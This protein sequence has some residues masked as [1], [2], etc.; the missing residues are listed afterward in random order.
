MKII[1]LTLL[2]ISML[3]CGEF[4]NYL[5][6]EKKAEV[7]IQ[8][9][10]DDEGDYKKAQKLGIEAL[11][12]F[13]NNSF[14][15]AYTGKAFY[16]EGDLESAKKYFMQAL[17]IDPTN[18]I[19][20]QFIQLIEKQSNA[21]ENK[22]V[23]SALTYLNDKG[24]DY[25]LIFLAFLGGETIARRYSNCQSRQNLESIKAFAWT[26]QNNPALIQ[27]FLYIIT[28]TIKNPFC[29]FLSLLIILTTTVAITIVAIWI[30]LSIYPFIIGEEQL[31]LI[32]IA[33][34][35]IYG[36]QLLLG[37]ILFFTI[38]NFIN[39]FKALNV[40]KSDVA[41]IMQNLALENNFEILRDCCIVINNGDFNHEILAQC[42]NTDAKDVIENM[43]KILKE[44]EKAKSV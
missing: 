23:S 7:S 24:L 22:D 4:D 40:A 14:I 16:S 41:D 20:S 25:L 5:T 2:S 35:G 27:K 30:E 8:Q 29:S 3:F 18:E 31:R 1:I 13:T 12:R 38:N 28:K 39:S 21:K 43:F 34:I 17:D 9:I 32:G 37:L 44:N 42:A 10:I 36:V 11:S 33:E 19:A 15:M 26:K 6:S